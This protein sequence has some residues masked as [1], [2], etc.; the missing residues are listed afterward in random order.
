MINCRLC[1]RNVSDGINLSDG[2]MIHESCLESIQDK[3]LKAEEELRELQS[4]L[5]G[6]ELEIEKREGI[7]FKIISIF[8]KP[9]VDSTE[10]EKAIQVVHNNIAH[11]SSVLSSI[12]SRLASLYDF[13]L[14][15]PPDWDERKNEVISRDGENCVECEGRR[16]LHLHHIKPLSKGGSN[17]ISNLELLCEDCHS[18]EHGGRDFSGAFINS[19]TAFS[20]R[21][22]NVRYARL[23]DA[24]HI[25]ARLGDALHIC[26]FRQSPCI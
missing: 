13:F 7:R 16:H 17:E 9:D 26:S 5:S 19:E 11:L 15:Y 4:K 1:N 22:S 23:G 20:K 21:V 24:L 6:F 8:S 2:G 25:C 10:I 12:Y 3:A 14:T 18:K